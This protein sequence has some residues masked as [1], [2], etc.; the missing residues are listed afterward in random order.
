VH[1]GCR[2]T[3]RPRLRAARANEPGAV[4]LGRGRHA[5]SAARSD[6]IGQIIAG[7]RPRRSTR[8]RRGH[9]ALYLRVPR[10]AEGAAHPA[11]QRHYDTASR[12]GS[13]TGAHR[14]MLLVGSSS[15]VLLLGLHR[16][17]GHIFA[18]RECRSDRCSC[19]FDVHGQRSPLK[20]NKKRRPRPP[21]KGHCSISVCCSAWSSLAPSHGPVGS[22]AATACCLEP[23]SSSAVCRLGDRPLGRSHLGCRYSDRA[24]SGLPFEPPMR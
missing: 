3:R 6:R 17:L 15:P 14:V 19:L 23:L 2:C 5:D 21:Q 24:S 13:R 16:G 7:M 10:L 22:W 20:R 18:G 4:A 8:C 9:L 12:A 11:R 1:R